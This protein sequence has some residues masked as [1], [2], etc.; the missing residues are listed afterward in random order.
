MP[1]R[2]KTTYSSRIVPAYFEDTL[3]DSGAWQADVYRLAAQWA[4]KLHSRVL[5]D[6]GCG[7]GSK[8]IRYGQ[9]FAIV[10]YDYGSNLDRARRY[11]APDA[12]WIPF[13]LNS[14][15]VPA[16]SF[17][18][19]VV[20]CADVI[21]HLPD[22]AALI[23]TLK[24]ASETAK[25]VLVS[26]PDRERVYKKDHDGPPVNPYHVRE[27]SNAELEVWFLDEGLPVRWAGWTVSND[28]WPDQM[29]T[30]LMVLSKEPQIEPLPLTFQPADRYRPARRFVGGERRL[31]VWMTP[32]PS[33]AGRDTTNAIHQVVCRLDGLLPDYGVEL[34]EKPEAADLKAGHAG[35][36]SSANV[37]VA[38]YHGLYNTAGG[39]DSPGFFAINSHVIQNLRSAKIITA[40]SEWIADVIRRDMHVNPEIIGWG[41]DTSEWT[42]V[43]DPGLYVLWN[44]ARVDAVSDPT[45]MLELA[46]AVPNMPFLT[47]FGEGGQNVKTV[48]RQPYEVMKNYV[49]NASVYLATV[50][51]T[52]GIATVEAM[53]AG[54]PILGF[55]HG[56]TAHL[57][58]HGVTGF[59]AEP[60]DINGLKEGLIYC[61]KHRDRLGANAREAAKYHTWDRV[62]ERMADV[63]RA[64]LE[65]HRGVKVSVIIPCHNYGE[66]VA[67]AIQ[68]VEDQ[69]AKFTFEIIVVLDRCTDNS[70]EVVKRFGHKVVTLTVDNGSLSKTRNDGISAATGEYIV[71]L[72]ADDRLGHSAFLQVLADELDKDRTLGIAFT[73]IR[74]MDADGNLGHVNA[75]PKGYDFDLQ[76]QKRNQVPSCCMFRKEAWRRAG[77]FRPHFRYAED[78]EF[79]LTVGAIGY[80]AKHVVQDGWFQYRLHNKS[81]S[82]VHRTGEIKEP[83]WTEF[84]PWTKDDQRPFAAGG[85][86]PLGSWP[87]RFYLKPDVTVILPVG[88]G[89]E[90][91]VKDALHSVEGQTHRYW[92]CI[93]VNDTGSK[94]DLSGFPW[95]KVIT[96]SGR[97]GAGA[98][99]NLGAKKANAPFLVFLDADDLLKPRFIEQTLQAYRLNGRYAYT[100]WMTDDGRGT[101][102]IHPTLDYSFQAVWERP[103]LHPVTALI[104]RKWFLDVDGFDEQMPA[105]EDVDLFMKLLTKGYCGVRVPE[106]LLIYNLES[107][108]RRKVGDKSK[109]KFKA[110]LKKRYGDF[111]EGKTMCDCIDPPKG[112]SAVPPTP[113]N[114]AEYREAYGEMVKVKYVH[115]FAGI[116]PTTLRGP[117][118]R[119]NYGARAKGDIFHIW[120]ADL[121][122]SDGVFEKMEFFEAE[123]VPTVVPPPP[124]GA[125]PVG[126]SKPTIETFLDGLTK[127]EMQKYAADNG[128]ELVPAQLKNRDVLIAAILEG[129]KAQAV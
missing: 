111:M 14:E 9:D 44:K 35:Q 12:H 103:S 71:C 115:E 28:A 101:V 53:A 96:T 117:A 89:H 109:A 128:I 86:P 47:T 52:F 129:S 46:A 69:L 106:P 72:D 122:N 114:A 31:K 121:D 73:G 65:P 13:D 79:W 2:L 5:V 19:A 40:P 64:A 42:P 126:D 107:G 37:D 4:E 93:V 59:L 110:T 118:T 41:V 6:L 30:S 23:Q 20:I 66:Y 95:A 49:R 8:L 50:T 11:K 16:A 108:F 123:P 81:A 100:D 102:E 97:V 55:R 18:D 29:H 17:Q 116:S 105:F 70:A 38:H 54:V 125:E 80:G 87:V 61:M 112:K 119:V 92:E 58:E 51:E 1:Y 33:E 77:G 78:A 84:H 32:T 94:L 48:G 3:T 90:E 57:V 74:I 36:G 60:G 22:P 21:E 25:C 113:E 43:S 39:H 76:A 98:A 99:R 104:P 88:E 10:G 24:N 62:A 68:S 34:V 56:N 120:Q 83:D 91:A 124:A 67:E 63:Y 82:Q 26:T 85:K 27:W 75:W 7:N 127:K 15:V 45:P